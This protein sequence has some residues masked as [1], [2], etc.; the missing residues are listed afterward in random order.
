MIYG[1][2]KNP[3]PSLKKLVCL[4]LPPMG[5]SGWGEREGSFFNIL[6]VWFIKTW[7]KNDEQTNM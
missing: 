3:G 6:K 7:N 1:K 2:R 4:E 5:F